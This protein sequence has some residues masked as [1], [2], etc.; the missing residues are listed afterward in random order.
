MECWFYFERIFFYQGRWLKMHGNFIKKFF[1]FVFSITLLFFGVAICTMS[2]Y[3]FTWCHCFS[4][5]KKIVMFITMLKYRC[6]KDKGSN[7]YTK[8]N[9]S[10]HHKNHCQSKSILQVFFPLNHCQFYFRKLKINYSQNF[11]SL[12]IFIQRKYKSN[13]FLFR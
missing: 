2:W 8:K 11:E 9:T 10:F 13:N 5:F 7:I 4:S 12:N 1:M 3:S 6:T